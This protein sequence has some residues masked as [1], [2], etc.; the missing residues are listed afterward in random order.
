MEKAKK[1]SKY[2]KIHYKAI[3]ETK[4]K[5]KQALEEIN[6]NYDI[7]YVLGDES[8]TNQVLNASVDEYI[9]NDK[10]N[11]IKK[12]NIYDKIEVEDNTSNVLLYL[13]EDEKMIKEYKNIKELD[14]INLLER[15]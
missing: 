15:I 5:I 4:E 9:A 8:E 11:N 1:T 7:I 13:S 2:I 12:V 6:K 14:I 3:S 10:D